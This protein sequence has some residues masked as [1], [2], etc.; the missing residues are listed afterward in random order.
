MFASKLQHSLRQKHLDPAIRPIL[1]QFIGSRRRQPFQH[2]ATPLVIGA[3]LS[4]VL[5]IVLDGAL[6][7]IQRR[8][9]PWTRATQS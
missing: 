8:V 3:V 9:T 5:A 2:F 4:I 6:V 1:H 7:F